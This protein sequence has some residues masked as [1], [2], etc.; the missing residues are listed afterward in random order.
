MRQIL[1]VFQEQLYMT[2]LKHGKWPEAPLKALQL[3]QYD[4]LR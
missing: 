3:H 4:L 2:R 1:C